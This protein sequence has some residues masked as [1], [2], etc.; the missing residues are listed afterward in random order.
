MTIEE[1]KEQLSE[2]IDDRKSFIN[3]SDD[4][5][6]RKDIEALEKTIGDS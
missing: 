2:L 6:Y 3:G 5:I 1:A 4:E